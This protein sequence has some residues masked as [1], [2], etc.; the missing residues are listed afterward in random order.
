MNAMTGGSDGPDDGTLSARPGKNEK[1]LIDVAGLDV[2]IDGEMRFICTLSNAT[3]GQFEMLSI[4]AS[5][6]VLDQN[7][8]RWLIPSNYSPPC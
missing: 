7:L 8:R 4:S 5:D 3:D 1:W 6:D 2:L